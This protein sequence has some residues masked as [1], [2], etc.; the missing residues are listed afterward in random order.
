MNQKSPDAEIFPEAIVFT[1]P[2][3]FTDVYGRRVLLQTAKTAFLG[4]GS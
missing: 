2:L 3:G 1:L 4:P